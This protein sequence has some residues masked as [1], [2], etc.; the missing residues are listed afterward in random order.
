MDIN[1]NGAAENTYE[2]IKRIADLV[3]G[4]NGSGL[5][6]ETQELIDDIREI[7]VE[8]QPQLGAYCMREHFIG[9]E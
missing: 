3:D 8:F 4:L 6:P 5:E 9:G 7:M 2:G 1:M